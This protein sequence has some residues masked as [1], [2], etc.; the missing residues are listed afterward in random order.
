MVTECFPAAPRGPE[1]LHEL[2]ALLGEQLGHLLV[3]PIDCLATPTASYQY[4]KSDSKTR[5]RV[6][7]VVSQEKKLSLSFTR[8]FSHGSLEELSEELLS[9]HTLDIQDR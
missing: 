5:A 9:Y 4:N 2:R 3:G 6:G 7:D 8:H 1:L